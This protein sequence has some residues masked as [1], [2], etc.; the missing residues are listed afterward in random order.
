MKT[1][2]KV[3]NFV[4][5]WMALIVLGVAALA[6]F[7][8]QTCTWIKTSWINWLLGIVMFGM[9]LTLKASD[10]AEVFKRPKDVVLGA[11]CQFTLSP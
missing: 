4:G 7:A 6:F 2:E 1:L 3:S 9:G 8:P 5:K 10:F 11:V